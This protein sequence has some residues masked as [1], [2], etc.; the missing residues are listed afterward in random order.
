MEFD[1]VELLQSKMSNFMSFGFA[2][3]AAFSAELQTSQLNM[4]PDYVCV[5]VYFGFNTFCI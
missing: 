2:I 3:V 1:K 5:A 4:F